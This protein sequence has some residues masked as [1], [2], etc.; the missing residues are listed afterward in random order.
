MTRGGWG[1]KKGLLWVRGSL[2]EPWHIRK[3]ARSLLD[4]AQC[5]QLC[6]P[7]SDSGP[8]KISSP[9]CSEAQHSAEIPLWCQ[10][11]SP[12]PNFLGDFCHWAHTHSE[13]FAPLIQFILPRLQGRIDGKEV[14]AHCWEQIRL[15]MWHGCTVPE[16]LHSPPGWVF[17]KHPE[18]PWRAQEWW[19]NGCSSSCFLCLGEDNVAGWVVVPSQQWL[20]T[21]SFKVWKVKSTPTVFT[22]DILHVPPFPSASGL[23]PAKPFLS[24]SIPEPGLTAP[25]NPSSAKKSGLSWTF[26]ACTS[27]RHRPALQGA[28]Q[29]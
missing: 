14:T 21:L 12:R 27:K 5:A 7:S 6:Q 29:N 25:K 13:C 16:V 26:W 20:R 19:D 11:R 28:F 10:C 17:K 23:L 4:M 18:Q 8:E 9:C 24:V 3:G 22:W 15:L 1:K 2:S